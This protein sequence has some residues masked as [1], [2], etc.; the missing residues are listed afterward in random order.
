MVTCRV[1]ISFSGARF[2]TD[3]HVLADAQGLPLTHI[4]PLL[5]PLSY[6]S[7]ILCVLGQL[8]LFNFS[9]KVHE[10]LAIVIFTWKVRHNHRKGKH[11]NLIEIQAFRMPV[12]TLKHPLDPLTADEILQVS[13]LLRSRTPDKSLHFKI[14]TILEPPKTQLRPFLI[15]ERN[16]G[17]QSRPSRKASSLYY[18]L[19][20]ADLFLAEV[21]LDTNSLERIKKLAPGLHGQNDIDES[22]ALRDAC[23]SH[24]K[25]LAEVKKFKLPEHLEVVCDPWPYGRDSEKNLP[26][27]VQVSYKT[28]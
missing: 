16:G 19:G 6:I 13:S 20:T 17:T 10:L 4:N 28:R 27:Y 2:A 22:M 26:R 14:I 25:V 11:V 18:H 21:N 8:F 23:L 3:K 15:A 7:F 24:P 1:P 12:S 5:R 9:R